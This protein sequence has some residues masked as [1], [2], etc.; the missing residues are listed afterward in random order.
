MAAASGRMM[1]RSGEITEPADGSVDSSRT[2]QDLPSLVVDAELAVFHPSATSVVAGFFTWD[3]AS[4]E[5]ICDP[6]TYRMHG[7]PE[8]SSAT[9]ETFLSRVPPADL[10]HVQEAMQ[11]MIASIGNYQIEY[12]VLHQDGSLRSMEARGRVMPGP[13][14]QPARMMGLVMDTTTMRAQREA[15][16]RRLRELAER[17][18]RTRDFT[19][20]L[21]SA[22]TVDAIID[23]AREG[24]RAYGA[25]SLILVASRD[26]R[27][28]VVASCG[29]DK[30]SVQALSGLESADPTP[31]SA[32]L[33][34][35]LPVYV[36]SPEVLARNYPQLAELVGRSPQQ[37]YVA[38]PVHDSA[39]GAGAC[40]FGFPDPHDFTPEERAL[41]YAASGLL[42]QS[43]E[44]ARMY[45]T[46]HAL[47]TELQ[48][49]MLPRGTLTA[50]GLTIATRYQP[51]TSGIEIG[52]DFYDVVQST[53]GQVALVIGDVQ[54]H[55]LLA[56]SLMGRLRTAVHAYTRE[57]HGPAE[58]MARTNRWLVNL[59]TDPDTA[60]FATCCFVVID[61]GSGDLALCRAGHPPPVLVTP[62][63]S[64]RILDCEAALPLGVEASVEYPIMSMRV[65]AGSVLALTT[66][67]F[68]ESEAGDDDNL[69]RLLDV[70]SQRP[71]DDLEE[72]A[73]ELL[74]C[75]QR[76]KRHGDDVALLLARLDATHLGG[77]R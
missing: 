4:G 67:G 37:A 3:L 75:I 50:P 42:A 16:E 31:I 55:N 59:N 65:E 5:V 24:L 23:A 18:S 9:M 14:G 20:A 27:L 72:L 36:S 76:P 62:G 52:G 46:Q 56:A 8:D 61:P 17:A 30:E 64:A 41:L 11:V 53:G 25:N 68:L 6:V 44:R 74:G 13:D 77:T 54:G 22:I 33:R 29:F 40:L 35:G 63:A 49:G 69:N 51:A 38:L 7:L 26:G 47:A 70:L 73:D 39:G 2:D 57:G 71:S 48:H 45:E 28:E 32:A 15:Q 19:A 60:L 1:T 34:G 43:L 21:A 10:A 58:V 12:R 66:D